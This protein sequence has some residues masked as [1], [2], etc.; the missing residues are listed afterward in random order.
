M[1][2]IFFWPLLASIIVITG[3]AVAPQEPIAIQDNVWQQNSMKVGVLMST[4]PELNVH[5]PGA[6]CLLC[7]AAAE[8]A[9]RSLSKHVDTLSHDDLP[10]MKDQLVAELGQKG[11]S[12]MSYPQAY[13]LNKLPDT[14]SDNSTVARKD[15][16]SFNDGS[17]LS[18][19][20]VIQVNMLGMYRPYSAYIPNSDPKAVFAGAIYLVNLQDNTYAW[21]E[22]VSIYRGATGEWDEPPSFPSLTNAWYQALEM[23]KKK[24]LATV[25]S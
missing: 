22:P 6:E 11:V 15:F 13:D 2:T 24:I 12:A 23:G 16:S 25:D 7:L 9:N 18:H 21:Y 17:G 14:K 19:L 10:R 4:V 3:C 1:K 20:L 5:M 8:I